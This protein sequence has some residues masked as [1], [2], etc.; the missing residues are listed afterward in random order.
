[1]LTYFSLLSGFSWDRVNFL[2]R[3]LYDVMFWIL[4]ENKGDSTQMFL[5]LPSGTYTEPR[6]FLLLMLPC[7]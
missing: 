5:L 1:M 6:M 4:D 2:C 7:Q 3:G